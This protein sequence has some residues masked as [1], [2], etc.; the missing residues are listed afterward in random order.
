MGL[1]GLV[2]KN[3]LGAYE[4]GKRHWLKVKKDY[5]FDGQIADAAD[6]VVLGA[7]FGSGKMGG[8]LSIYLMGSWDASQ[9]RW[10]TVTKVHTGLDDAAASAVHVS[11]SEMALHKCM[12]CGMVVCNVWQLW[13]FDRRAE[14]KRA[15]NL[16]ACVCGWVRRKFR[17]RRVAVFRSQWAGAQ[18]L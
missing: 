12:N 3:V 1:E 6:L 17:I 14:C 11:T 7:W 9:R 8:R 5:L 15:K 10:C 16:C 2:L 18:M 13:W 4:P